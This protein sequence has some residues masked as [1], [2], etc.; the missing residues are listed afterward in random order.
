MESPGPSAEAFAFCSRCC[1]LSGS[2]R[3]L[4]S[5]MQRDA[6]AA[7]SET[8][9]GPDARADFFVRGWTWFGAG[10][11]GLEPA[12]SSRD[13]TAGRRLGAAPGRRLEVAAARL[14]GGWGVM[15]GMA[16]QGSPAPLGS[17][18]ARSPVVGSGY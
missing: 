2:A 13:S 11:R 10:N 4:R 17:D 16:P 8:R 12:D 7:G 5:G 3:K 18:S 14:A 15:A 1:G 9:T 6:A